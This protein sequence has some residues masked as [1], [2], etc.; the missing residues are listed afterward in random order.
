M[1]A[2]ESAL[3]SS[4]SRRMAKSGLVR[5]LSESQALLARTLATVR[6]IKQWGDTFKYQDLG[7]PSLHHL[8]QVK[9]CIPTFPR[10]LACHA[11]PDEPIRL[12]A[13]PVLLELINSRIPPRMRFSRLQGRAAS[14]SCPGE[15]SLTVRVSD[16]GEL[17]LAEFS[18]VWPKAPHMPSSFMAHLTASLAGCL[19]DRSAPLSLLDGILHSVHL[20]GKFAA[21]LAEIKKFAPT[22][23]TSIRGSSDR[24]QVILDYPGHGRHSFLVQLSHGQ[25]IFASSG[26]V[27]LAMDTEDGIRKRIA[28]GIGLDNVQDNLRFACDA[29]QQTQ[30]FALREALLFRPGGG[31]SCSP[32][33][34]STFQARSVMGNLATFRVNPE[35]GRFLALIEYAPSMSAKSFETWEFD[36]SCPA[37]DL[38]FANPFTRISPGVF[39]LS[40]CAAP[41]LSFT[42]APM[43]SVPQLTI[44]GPSSGARLSMRSIDLPPSGSHWDKLRD[45]ASMSPALVFLVHTSEKLLTEY[46]TGSFIVDHCLRVALPLCEISI[47]AKSTGWRLVAVCQ[48]KTYSIYSP[49][50]SLQAAHLAASLAH[51]VTEWRGLFERL[52]P[53]A[54]VQLLHDASCSSLIGIGGAKLF[55]SFGSTMREVYADTTHVDLQLSFRIESY[56]HLAMVPVSPLNRLLAEATKW[57]GN[58]GQLV[59]YITHKLTSVHTAI[60]TFS[61]HRSPKWSVLPQD[62]FGVFQLVYDRKY[63][64]LGIPGSM[65]TYRFTYPKIYPDHL[66]WH[67]LSTLVPAGSPPTPGNYH[68]WHMKYL[69]EIR[70]RAALLCDL[71]TLFEANGFTTKIEVPDFKQMPNAVLSFKRDFGC[72]DAEIQITQMITSY[73]IGCEDGRNSLNSLMA[74]FTGEGM[75]RYEAHIARGIINLMT[76]F[77]PDHV[78]LM[79]IALELLGGARRI[80]KRQLGSIDRLCEVMESARLIND[81]GVMEYHLGHRDLTLQFEGTSMSEVTLHYMTDGGWRRLDLGELERVF[82]LL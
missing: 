11:I 1:V 75:L 46:E 74:A 45:L 55:L 80:G 48:G 27:H 37:L 51:W 59:P 32:V 60:K 78:H 21:I 63:C 82:Q 28:M 31:I 49:H 64:L 70:D 24:S 22:F 39:G 9:A 16:Q 36:F 66:F 10:A 52:T 12:P 44:S 73:R 76:T 13:M 79:K 71:V 68:H 62:S 72:L 43:I 4:E 26:V 19:R 33:R 41:S 3:A 7:S 61:S 34:N 50:F 56:F 15:Y 8:R 65:N 42:M 57:S 6:W 17:R 40:Y 81:C 54:N 20:S 25:I 23:Q 35:N 69:W 67:V 2:S 30:L 5:S 58:V 38:A 18:V 14:F 77:L 53:L 29:V 47:K